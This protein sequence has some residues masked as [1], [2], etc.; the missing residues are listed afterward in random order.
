MIFVGI[1]NGLNGGIVVLDNDGKVIEVYNMPVLKLEKTEYDVQ[2]LASILSNIQHAYKDIIVG[3]EKAHVRPVQGIRAA[4]TTGY[5]LGLMQGILQSLKVSYEVVNP[6]VWMKCVF[7]GNYSKENK[8]YST[9][10][11]SRRYP[12]V[13][14]KQGKKNIHDGLTDSCAIA[15]YTFIKYNKGVLTNEKI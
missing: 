7:E 12:D 5:G 14:W 10:W 6:T 15:F 4:F 3:L 8:K 1:D 11:A 13:D 2:E 9:I